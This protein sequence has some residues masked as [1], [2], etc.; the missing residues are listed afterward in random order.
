[1]LRLQHPIVSS[2]NFYAIAAN[3]VFIGAGK[4]LGANIFDQNRMQLMLGTKLSDKFSLEAGYLNQ[5]V[6]Q[7]RRVN[8]MTIMQHNNGISL[9]AIINL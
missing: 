7:G 5:T 9:A 4:N 6:M 2:G 1:M 3:E 8:D